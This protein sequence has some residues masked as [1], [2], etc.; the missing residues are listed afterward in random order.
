MYQATLSDL[1]A[2]DDALY[3][4]FS[5]GFDYHDA[6]ARVSALREPL[7]ALTGFALTLDTSVQD[8][9]FFT[10]FYARDPVP[11]PHPKA[12]QV[13]ETFIAIRFSSFA[14]FFTIWGCSSE[15]PITDELR[16]RVAAFVSQ[17]NFIYVPPDILDQPHPLYGTWWIRYFDYL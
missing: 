1:T 5:P 16:T 3:D 17:H 4:E 2:A 6:L 15:R 9:S 11:R 8:A 14:D 13:I 7:E 12:G 10:E